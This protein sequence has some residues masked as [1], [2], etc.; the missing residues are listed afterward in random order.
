MNGIY[1]WIKN[2]IEVVSLCK[3]VK[4]RIAYLLFVVLSC[5]S[6]CFQLFW[7]CGSSAFHHRTK[8]EKNE[9]KNLHKWKVSH[10][11]CNTFLNRL[12]ILNSLWQILYAM[13][14]QVKPHKYLPHSWWVAVYI[15][16]NVDWLN[17]YYCFL[18]FRVLHFLFFHFSFYLLSLGPSSYVTKS[19][20]K[21]KRR[22][23]ENFRLILKKKKKI[24]NINR[25]PCRVYRR[26]K[27]LKTEIILSFIEN[28]SN[29]QTPLF[30]WANGLDYDIVMLQYEFTKQLNSQHHQLYMV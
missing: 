24:M 26:F 3:R 1:F 12:R 22:V 18:W 15:L 16:W 14:I 27:M 17:L 9:K 4:S 6:V 13:R 28:D 19:V 7:Q 10:W 2:V 30:V 20:A 29:E 8:N 5:K 25:N 23:R 21:M 11:S